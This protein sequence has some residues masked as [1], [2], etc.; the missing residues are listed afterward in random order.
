M[1]TETTLFT[2]VE[3]YYRDMVSHLENARERIS[4]VFL[5]FVDGYWARRIAEVL[6]R[7]ATQGLDVRLMVDVLGQLSDNPQQIFQNFRIL[8]DLRAAGLTVDLFSPRG[9]GL[10]LLNRQHCKFCAIDHKTAYVGGSNIGDYYTQYSD[11]HLRLDGNLGDT[12]HTIYDYLRQFSN[13]SEPE[14]P[15]VD[16]CNLMAGDVRLWLTVPSRCRHIHEA[17]LDLIENARHSIYI[18]TWYFLPDKEILDALCNKA[19]RGVRVNVLLSHKTRIPPVD[20]ANF[21][22]AH[23][24]A[25]CGG[26]IFRYV[27]KYMHA[28]VAW[29]DRGEVLLGSANLDPHS[30]K[31]NFEIFASLRDTALCRQLLHDFEAGIETSIAQTADTFL[32]LSMPDKALSYVC[33]LASA[34]L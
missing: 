3:D 13:L 28:K 14:K 18:R 5:A 10:T 30:M 20:A 7:K 29:N 6:V 31:S 27:G 32:R 23:R 15:V 16:P 1:K 26:R 24:L 25:A 9:K 2:Q 22:H 4:M 12:F 19:A 8:R 11:T 34:W 21:L 17:L 33:N